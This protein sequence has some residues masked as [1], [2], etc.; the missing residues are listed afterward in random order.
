MENQ[1]IVERLEGKRIA[2][3]L[4]AGYFG[5]YHQ[6]GVLKALIEANVRPAYICGNS[7]GA[8]VASMYAAGLD[9]PE[10]KELLLSLNRKDFWDMQWPLDER[11]FG[12][13]GGGRFQNELSR[14]L[15]VATFEECRIPLTVGAYDLDVGR[16]KYFS[17]GP[18]IPSVYASCALPYLF[19]PVEINGRRYWD[20]GFA[21]K[22]P[23]SPF[24]ALDDVDVVLISYLPPRDRE[25]QK[26]TG[27]LRFIPPLSALFADVPNDERKERDRV[28]VSLL[29]KSGKEVIALAPP[30]LALGPFSLNMAKSSF[31][32]GEKGAAALLLS[33]DEGAM[34]KWW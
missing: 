15:P 13:L 27:L 19:K 12:L 17:S 2:L 31:E 21:E 4:S 33:D 14:V 1:S 30:R 6:A 3:A 10:I 18:L 28:A 24:I 23:L 7:A 9:P 8:L 16:V 29:Q 26:C 22:T 34:P 11:G 5:F 32:Q 20:G 25:T